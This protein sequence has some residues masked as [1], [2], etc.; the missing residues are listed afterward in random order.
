MDVNDRSSRQRQ[1]LGPRPGAA[2]DHAGRER[3]VAERSGREAA[4]FRRTAPSGHWCGAGVLG[5]RLSLATPADD[6]A[7]THVD[8]SLNALRARRAVETPVF[9]FTDR[10]SL[11]ETTSR[12]LFENRTVI[13]G[14][15]RRGM[16]PPLTTRYLAP[17][18]FGVILHPGAGDPS[19]MRG[20]ALVLRDRSSGDVQWTEIEFSLSAG[21]AAPR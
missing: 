9:A 18:P 20:I 19:P 16:R 6:T 5:G 21:S 3:I 11:E 17:T 7:L 14:W 13:E 12:V 8:P 2:T 10:N 1:D 4:R 15:L